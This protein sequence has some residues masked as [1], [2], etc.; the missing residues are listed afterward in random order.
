M[1]L[2]RERLQSYLLGNGLLPNP[3]TLRR[4]GLAAWAYAQLPLEHPQRAGLRS[5]FLQLLERHQRIKNELQPLLHAWAD[6]GI[7]L[8]LFKGFWLA[9]RVYPVPGTRFFGDVDILIPPAQINTAA[10]TAHEQ[11]WLNRSVVAP[12]PPYRHMAF[13]L[14][15]P[16]GWTQVDAHRFLLHSRTPWNSR[17][18]RITDA[19][20]A[21]AHTW[22]WDGVRL[23]E[24]AAVD[25]AIVLMLQRCWGDDWRLKPADTIDL[26]CLI[27]RGQLAADDVAKRAAEL[28][29][30]RTVAIF[31]ERCNPWRRTLDLRTPTHSQSWRHSVA[32]FAERPFLLVDRAVHRT[33]TLLRRTPQLLLNVVRVLPSV[34]RAS[35]AL[36]T[37]RSIEA[38]LLAVTPAAAQDRCTL[39]H[40]LR[41]EEGVR[42]AIRLLTFG[43]SPCLWRALA[44][45]HALRRHDWP[46]VFVSGVQRRDERIIG[47]AWIELDGR[48]LAGLQTSL[49]DYAIMFRYPAAESGSGV[50]PLTSSSICNRESRPGTLAA[51]A[52][53]FSGST[54]TPAAS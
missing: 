41:I 50:Q 8:L 18:Q 13:S 4:S 2:E 20:W 39:Q 36:R 35:W 1:H 44:L 10:S 43:R 26:S 16:G 47:H 27:A 45:Y 6:A 25:A 52:A 3:E 34:A 7:E 54:G 22:L 53:R 30:V 21:S 46:V 14:R 15:K 5:S 23:R 19:M 28:G 49:S 33:D 42:Q 31:L 11:G 32:I 17:Q 24:L 40:R 48:M 12:P 37:Q 9:E 29:C 51:K 38:M